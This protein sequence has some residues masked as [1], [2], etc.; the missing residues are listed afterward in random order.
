MHIEVGVTI[1]SACITLSALFESETTSPGLTSRM[2]SKPNVCNAPVSEATACPPLGNNPMHKGR[3]PHGS[4]AAYTQS[5]V[6]ITSEYAPTHF[7]IA[8]LMRS[9]HVASPLRASI[10]VITSVSDEEEN[11]TPCSINSLRSSAELIRFPL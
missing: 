9:S 8:A 6:R 4:R 7:F 3:K 2:A 10:M 11:P 5:R 1:G